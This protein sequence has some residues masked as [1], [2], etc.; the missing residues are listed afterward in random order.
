MSQTT[1]DLLVAA[2]KSHWVIPRSDS[3]VAKGKGVLETFWLKVNASSGSGSVNGSSHH[4]PVDV[5]S[6]MVHVDEKSN[7]QVQSRKS[8]NETSDMGTTA[9][10]QSTDPS[11]KDQRLVEWNYAVLLERLHAIV[12]QRDGDDATIDP[13]VSAQLKQ[14]VT[15]IAGKYN[16]NAFHNF[17]H[18][19][20]VTLS[21]TKLLSRIVTYSH[22]DDSS[23]Q[24]GYT[25]ELKSDALM[26]FAVVLSA[27]IHDVDHEGVPNVQLVRENAAI[28][29]FYGNK[30][31]A[32]RNSITL[33]WELFLRPQ[34][35]A[36]RACI[37]PR[38][39]DLIRFDGI[40]ANAVLATG[41]YLPDQCGVH[42]CSQFNSHSENS[43]ITFYLSLSLLQI[44]SIRSSRRNGTSAGNR[45]SASH[46]RLKVRFQRRITSG[47]SLCWST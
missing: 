45:Y 13:K 5:S 15:A 14:Y 47:L 44:S 35:K 12:Q 22:N 39:S 37:C 7:D 30:S 16:R 40:V 23:E 20:H 19:S 43:L 11:N 38:Q 36:L 6:N 29:G 28:A 3:V 1:A 18:A 46:R 21:V 2:G 26:Q 41:T 27:L 31:V 42:C 32:E 17:E 25:K 24:Q 34:Y 4:S 33:S 9:H 10:G 8:I